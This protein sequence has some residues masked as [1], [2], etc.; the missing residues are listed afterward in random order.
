MA[1]MAHAVLKV[2][3]KTLMPPSRRASAIGTASSTL[4]ITIT[5]MTGP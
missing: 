3:S 4:S 2:T 5:G 1:S